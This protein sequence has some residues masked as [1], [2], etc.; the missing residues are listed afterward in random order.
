MV[1]SRR[2]KSFLLADELQRRP[3]TSDSAERPRPPSAAARTDRELSDAHAV[4]VTSLSATWD[5][6]E[7]DAASATREQRMLLTGT[8]CRSDGPGSQQARTAT[9]QDVSLLCERSSRFRASEAAFRLP[10]RGFAAVVGTVGS[11]KSSLLSAII[12]Q[13]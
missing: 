10:R 8:G 7:D 5:D 9:L 12:G 1:S 13:L 4:C 11:G 6:P 2:L 3:A